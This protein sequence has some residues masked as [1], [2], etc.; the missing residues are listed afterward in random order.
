MRCHC[1]DIADAIITNIVV[2]D[3]LA[4]VIIA[5]TAN[6]DVPSPI[7]ADTDMV[8]ADVVVMALIWCC[9]GRQRGSHVQIMCKSGANQV[10]IMVYT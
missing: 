10:C 5:L 3:A 2:A 7:A 4:D 8:I 6:S 1:T 9:E